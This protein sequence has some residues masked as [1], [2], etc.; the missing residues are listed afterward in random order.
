MTDLI[1]GSILELGGEVGSTFFFFFFSF[2]GGGGGAQRD[3]EGDCNRKLMGAD[4][5]RPC[6]VAMEE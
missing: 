3:W 1:R 2:F 5:S 6:M 4:T